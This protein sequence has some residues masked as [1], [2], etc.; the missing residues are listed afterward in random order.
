M[1]TSM[2]FHAFLAKAEEVAVVNSNMS[3]NVHNGVLDPLSQHYQ[4][5]LSRYKVKPLGGCW[6]IWTS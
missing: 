5:A 3:S 6:E 2:V 4:T 1:S